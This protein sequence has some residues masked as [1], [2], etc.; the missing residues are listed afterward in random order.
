METATNLTPKGKVR[1]KKLLDAAGEVFLEEGFEKAGMNQIIQRSGGS[2]STVYKIFGN[3]EGLFRAILTTKMEEIY[4]EIE[5]KNIAYGQGL[6]GFL[7]AVGGQYLD[8]VTTDEAV[9]FH[10]LIISEGWRDGAKF[11]KVFL[12]HAADKLSAL[13]ASRL[14]EEKAQGNIDLE[15]AELASHQFL[16]GIKD[17]FLFRRVLGVEIDVSAQTKAKA[18]RQLV[19]IFCRGIAKG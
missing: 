17:P 6:E 7:T 15:D 9:R 11:G 19:K 1:Y 4:E 18:V 13:V 14:H 12:E 5:Q 2:L 8:L 10:R 3:K 16:H